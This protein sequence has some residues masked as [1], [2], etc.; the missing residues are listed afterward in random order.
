M[1]LHIKF[2]AIKPFPPEPFATTALTTTATTTASTTTASTTT[3]S[4]TDSAKSTTVGR[5]RVSPTTRNRRTV[6]TT[7][8]RVPSR[9]RK[10]WLPIRWETDAWKS[11]SKSY[12]SKVLFYIVVLILKAKSS[13]VSY[14][15]CKIKF[16]PYYLNGYKES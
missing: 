4:R 14:V 16:V 10:T 3:A 15:Y 13:K 5:T 7:T 6:K 11:T 12:Y 2:Q 1:F 8:A 9:P